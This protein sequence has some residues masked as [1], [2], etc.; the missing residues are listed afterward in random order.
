MKH[1]VDL[2]TMK[3]WALR[4]TAICI[5]IFA[6]QMIFPAITKDFALVSSQVLYRPWTIVTYIFLHANVPHLLYN[7]FAL[8]LFGTILES[9]IGWKRFLQ[10]FFAAGVIAGLAAVPFYASVIGAS[11]AIFGILGCLAVLR[12]R[13]IVWVFGVPMPMIMA[14]ALWAII[15]SIGVFAPLSQTAHISHLAGLAV[16]IVLGLYLWEHCGESIFKKKQHHVD[17]KE[18]DEW[19]DKWMGQR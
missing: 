19:E 16:G 2:S 6:L 4:L 5:I 8:A 10:L 9:V 12:P 11:G 3:W 13:T 7:M 17:E 1:K 14:A 18:L 15:D